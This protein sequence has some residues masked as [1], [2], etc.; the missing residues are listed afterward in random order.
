MTKSDIINKLKHF[1][2]YDNILIGENPFNQEFKQICGKTQNNMIYK[3]ILKPNHNGN[4]YCSCK[5]IEFTPD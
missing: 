4:C 2:D 5:N 1:N 3:C